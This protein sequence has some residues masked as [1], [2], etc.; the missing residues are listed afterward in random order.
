MIILIYTKRLQQV[1]KSCICLIFHRE[2]I[3]DAQK[4]SILLLKIKKIFPKL[5]EESDVVTKKTEITSKE[6]IFDELLLN[7]RDFKDGNKIDEIWFEVYK[8]FEEDEKWKN[9]LE[10]A[11]K[12]L[13]FSNMPQNINRENIQKM[14]GNTLKTSVSKLES[15]QKCPFSFYLQYGLKLKDK[16]GFKLERLDIGTFMHD[17]IDSFFGE[18]EIRRFRTE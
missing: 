8:I 13:E 2:A 4:P 18:I 6:A 17:V 10:N 12:G 15:Y 7:I 3:G 9:R 5:I 11:V 1:K 16:Q 14:Y